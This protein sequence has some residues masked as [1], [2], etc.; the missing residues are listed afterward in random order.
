MAIVIEATHTEDEF[1]EFRTSVVLPNDN[2]K[3][4]V[5]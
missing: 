2:E 1:Q 3:E 5:K 4:Q